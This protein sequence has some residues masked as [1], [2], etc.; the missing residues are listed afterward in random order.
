MISQVQS[1]QS[2]ESRIESFYTS[3]TAQPQFSSVESV[4][5]T[6]IPESLQQQMN[7]GGLVPKGYATQA[8]FSSLPQDVKDYISS[9][10]QEINSIIGGAAPGGGPAATAKA[11]SAKAT[12]AAGTTS[13]DKKDASS[14]TSASSSAPASTPSTTPSAKSASKNFAAIQTPGSEGIK[15]AFMGV[16]AAVAGGVVLL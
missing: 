15:G 5:V 12:G 2:V 4:L 13:A 11:S 16:M 9:A 3:L 10:G 7:G 8:W 14:S 6:A 1:I